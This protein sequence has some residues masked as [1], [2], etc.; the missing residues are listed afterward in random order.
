[1]DCGANP[2]RQQRAGS[3]VAGAEIIAVFGFVDM[4]ISDPEFK[5]RWFA[6]PLVRE[7]VEIVGYKSSTPPEESESTELNDDDLALLRDIASGSL[8]PQETGSG[9]VDVLLTKLG[10][11]SPAEALEYAIKTGVSWQ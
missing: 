9:E 5:A 11:A 2:H 1:M 7:L 10:V 4:S 3:S 6:L 8:A